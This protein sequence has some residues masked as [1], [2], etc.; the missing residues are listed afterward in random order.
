ME[1]ADDYPLFRIERAARATDPSSSFDAAR[2]VAP[3]V[4]AGQM[5]ALAV[6]YSDPSRDFDDFELEAATGVGQTSIG[7]R[8]GELQLLGYVTQTGKRLSSSGLTRRKV[9][10]CRI[11]EDGMNYYAR[12]INK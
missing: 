5:K 11:T 2:A 9:M 8:R 3:F 12:E 6:F 1:A 10:A 7:K 4:H